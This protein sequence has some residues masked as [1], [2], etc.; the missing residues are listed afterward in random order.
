[1][2]AFQLPLQF[3]R[4]GG[5]GIILLGIRLLGILKHILW[6]SRD[7]SC[8]CF[9]VGVLRRGIVMRS[10]IGHDRPPRWCIL[11]QETAREYEKEEDQR[12]TTSRNKGVFPF[13]VNCYWAVLFLG[14][15][16]C[17][18]LRFLPELG[19]VPRRRGAKILDFLGNWDRA[20]E[21]R[22]KRRSKAKRGK[23]KT[24]SKVREGLRL[25]VHEYIL[26]T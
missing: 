11:Y 1:M 3:P 13:K 20:V 16:F 23:K 6:L 24:L 22:G 17:R 21:P 15:F 4:V 8:W 5:V 18:A 12:I 14:I 10:H 26:G 2:P 25:F 19:G 7:S 9:G